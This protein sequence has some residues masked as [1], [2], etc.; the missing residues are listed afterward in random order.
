MRQRTLPPQARFTQ[1]IAVS[2]NLAVTRPYK[3]LSSE[4]HHDTVT[5]SI[6]NSLPLTRNTLSLL[7]QQGQS[8]R[9]SNKIARAA[10]SQ[11][12]N[13]RLRNYAEQQRM[14]EVSISAFS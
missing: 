6:D 5:Q 9:H 7:W 10:F 8:E 1:T 13:K 14:L 2:S 11:Q 4:T 12:R 3:L